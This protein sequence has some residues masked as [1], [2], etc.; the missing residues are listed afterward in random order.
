MHH[1]VAERCGGNQTFLGVVNVKAV[2][3]AGGVGLVLEFALEFQQIIFKAIFK[4]GDVR[5]TAFAARG[6]AVG[7]EEV[8]PGG[9]VVVHH[10]CRGEALTF[11]AVTRYAYASVN[12]SPLPK[13]CPARRGNETAFV[14]YLARGAAFYLPGAFQTQRVFNADAAHFAYV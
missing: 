11:A 5:M 6:F 8:V 2:I 12:A 10:K 3:R 9:E 14:P 4:R 1:A 7:A 13:D